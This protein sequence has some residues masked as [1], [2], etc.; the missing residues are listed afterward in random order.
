MVRD[1]QQHTT[2]QESL[3]QGK[4]CKTE[5]KINKHILLD[6]FRKDDVPFLIREL[7]DVAPRWQIF[8]S[9]LG[10]PISELNII[11]AKPLLLSGAPV[12]YL[13]DALDHWI[14]SERSTLGILCEALKT[15]VVGEDTLA[16]KVKTRFWD[17]RG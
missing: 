13:Q 2:L 16:A 14:S 17:Y 10:V 7:R 11:A 5:T 12:T 15:E 4:C 1:I 8:C 3:P 9:Q 6:V